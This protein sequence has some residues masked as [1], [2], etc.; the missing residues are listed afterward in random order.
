MSN[1]KKGNPPRVDELPE[2][3]KKGFFARLLKIIDLVNNVNK[4]ITSLLLAGRFVYGCVGHT[5][6]K[7]EVLGTD[8]DSIILKAS[9]TGPKLRWS[10][11]SDYRVSFGDLPIEDATLQLAK[12]EENSAI[13]TSI[14]SG[15]MHLTVHGLRSKC[16]EP[17]DTSLT[18]R[19]D[20][21][22]IASQIPGKSVTLTI[23]V[24]ESNGET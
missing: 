13:V 24:R 6:T 7:V 12:G 1:K 20:K 14:G 9:I 8:G 17:K 2:P 21:E 18:D 16:R 11:L 4:I 22:E 23:V 15:I 19:Y 5:K 3:P 10:K